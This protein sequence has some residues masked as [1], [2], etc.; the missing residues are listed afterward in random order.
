M[1]GTYLARTWYERR[2]EVEGNDEAGRGEG[3]PNS[4]ITIRYGKISVGMAVSRPSVFV[5]GSSFS[6]TLIRKVRDRCLNVTV[7]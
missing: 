3:C 2:L 5:F 6:T 7:F 4:A 1:G